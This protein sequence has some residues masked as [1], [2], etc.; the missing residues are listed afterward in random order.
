MVCVGG[1][2][3]L[4]LCTGPQSGKGEKMKKNARV[5]QY[6]RDFPINF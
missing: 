1:L 3:R 4:V 6:F 2:L 5:F